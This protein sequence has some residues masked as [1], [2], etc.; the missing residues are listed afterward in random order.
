MGSWLVCACGARL[1]RN[2]FSGAGIGIIV[3]E[4]EMDAVA[5]AETGDAIVPRLIRASSLLI[6]CRACG[7]LAVE[8]PDGA[9][10]WYLPEG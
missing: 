4:A 10:D 6:R 2:L 7:R 8:G 5:D 3:P 1:H 9:V